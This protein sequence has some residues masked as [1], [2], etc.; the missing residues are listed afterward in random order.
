MKIRPLKP[1]NRER[2]SNVEHQTS[3]AEVSEVWR[4][5]SMFGVGCS[6]FDV[7]LGSRV[8]SFRFCACIGT[9]N[10]GA[11]LRRALTSY[12]QELGLA[13]TL[14][15]PGSWAGNI[16]TRPSDRRLPAAA[17]SCRSPFALPY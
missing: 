5:H 13:R 7:P 15:P 17:D 16:S 3:K 8:A 12:G 6:T 9:V 11:R 14:A 1:P 10:G 4:G 2:T